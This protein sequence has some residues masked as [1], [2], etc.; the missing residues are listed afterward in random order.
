MA[1]LLDSCSAEAMDTHMDLLTELHLLDKVPTLERLRTAQKRR[2][3]QL[4]RWAQYEKDLQHKKRKHEKRRNVVS[5]KKV[6]FESSVAL[7]EASLRNDV[8]EGKRG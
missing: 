6:S 3:Q 2:A 5:C 1:D 8:E 4:K 7:L